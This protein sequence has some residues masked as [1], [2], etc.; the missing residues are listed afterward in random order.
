MHHPP[1]PSPRRS[2]AALLVDADTLFIV[3]I[4]IN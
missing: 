2:L 1:T 3:N 4:S